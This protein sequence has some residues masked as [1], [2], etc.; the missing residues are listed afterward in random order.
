MAISKK[1]KEAL[2]EQYKE[3][4]QS[5]SAMVFTGYAGLGVKEIEDLRNKLREIGSEYFIVKNT[6][7]MRA[8]EEL[9][10]EPPGDGFDGPTAISTTSE[11]VP[12]ML[13]TL[14]DLTKEQEVFKVRGAIIDGALMSME[15]VRQ[16]AE[17]PPMPVLQ[18]Q[19]L[20]VLNSPATQLVGVFAGSLRQLVNV[21][22]A[23]S[24]AEGEAAPAA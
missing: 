15:E 23:Y 3:A 10:I 11:D 24:E 20:S 4:L 14:V 17:L 22:K 6:I 9:G 13:K 18:S 8:F 7:A 16:L 1:R 12:A 21:L 5:N 2:L 19:F